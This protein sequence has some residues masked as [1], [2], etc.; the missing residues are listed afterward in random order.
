VDFFASSNSANLASMSLWGQVGGGLMSAVG[1]FYSAKAQRANLQAQAAMAQTN[2]RLSERSAQSALA[3]GQQQYGAITMQAG[4]LQGRQTAAQAANN[5]D[6]GSG[7]A[8]EVRASSKI[9]SQIDANQA[10]SNAV[11]SAWG[12]RTQGVNYQNQALMARANASTINPGATAAA[13][14][15]GSAG[16]VAS[17]WYQF[18][19][20][21]ASDPPQS[22][23]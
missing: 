21:G 20:T 7:S 23:W 1:G 17:S 10:L 11:Q 3:Q 2:A 5:L 19:K 8:A 16:Q 4:Q 12:Y 18:K 6:L 22:D 9:L 14:L 13:S 15:L